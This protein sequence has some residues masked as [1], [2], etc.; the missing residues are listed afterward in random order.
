LLA[1]AL[2]DRDAESVT[3]ADAHGE[4]LALGDAVAL[5]RGDADADTEL[6]ADADDDRLPP[7]AR[8]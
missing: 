8:L 1:D 5:C 7:A 4:R 6:H 2:E 3:N